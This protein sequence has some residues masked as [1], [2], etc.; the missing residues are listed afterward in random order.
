MVPIKISLHSHTHT[1]AHTRTHHTYIVCMAIV[2]YYRLYSLRKCI[3]ERT[4]DC[5]IVISTKYLTIRTIMLLNLFIVICYKSLYFKLFQALA[6]QAH[7][8]LSKIQNTC[9]NCLLRTSTQRMKVILL[10]MVTLFLQRDDKT[11]LTPGEYIN[12]EN[13]LR[14]QL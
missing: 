14:K 7:R 9:R 10:N 12:Y 13:Q 6:V 11:S 5:N 4:I 8:R 1:R 2:F 3:I